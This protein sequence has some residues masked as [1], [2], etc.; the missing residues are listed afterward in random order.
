MEERPMPRSDPLRARPRAQSPNRPIRRAVTVAAGLPPGVPGRPGSPIAAL[1][2]GADATHVV[3]AER[4]A[5]AS[6]A[7]AA[8]RA[9]G[10]TVVSANAAIGTFKVTASSD[11]FI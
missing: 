1:G 6:D 7:R 11:A 4:G 5:S 3:A 9:A 8:I 2:G 10:G